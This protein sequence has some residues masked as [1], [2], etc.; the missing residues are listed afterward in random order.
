MWRHPI[1]DSV[2]PLSV[3]LS[4]AQGSYQADCCGG[5]RASGDP[6]EN[7]DNRAIRSLAGDDGGAVDTILYCGAA[8]GDGE[9]VGVG[10]GEGVS[11]PRGD[12]SGVGGGVISGL[13]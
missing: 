9:A 11:P 4:V 13:V 8:V 6:A 1:A 2:G 12:D 10:E 7:V 3:T 5:H